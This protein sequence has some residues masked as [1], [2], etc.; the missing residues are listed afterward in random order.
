MAL[1]LPAPLPSIY[2]WHRIHFPV[3]S[4]TCEPITTRYFISTTATV[5]VSAVATSCIHQTAERQHLWGFLLFFFFYRT[6]CILA[7]FVPA[8]KSFPVEFFKWINCSIWWRGNVLANTP[9]L[10][11]Q[12]IELLKNT[13]G[14]H[15]GKSWYRNSF[16]GNRTFQ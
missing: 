9:S 4:C 2:R 8:H 3:D 1:P 5:C 7:M 14:S 12:K 13:T 11:L 10:S 15:K 16:R 6:L